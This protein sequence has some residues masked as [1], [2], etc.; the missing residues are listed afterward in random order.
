MTMPAHGHGTHEHE[1]H[2]HVLPIKTY[3]GVFGALIFLT[4]ITVGVS[5]LNLG[6]RAL[7]VAL[8]VALVKAGLV[9]GYFMHLKFD[10][11]FHSFV[12]FSSIIFLAIFFGFTFMDLGSRTTMVAE[13]GTFTFVQEKDLERLGARPEGKGPAPDKDPAAIRP[14]TAPKVSLPA[15]PAPPPPPAPPAPS[16]PAPV[17]QGAA[18]SPAPIPVPA[19][20]P[21]PTK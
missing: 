12:F 5:Y 13:Q 9:V 18:P 10:V 4:A 6:P 1:H 20:P 21:A 14:G 7:L 3:F 8:V 19:A 17:P 16:A 15:P 2:D 11:R